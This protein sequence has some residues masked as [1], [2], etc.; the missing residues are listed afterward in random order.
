MTCLE[1]QHIGHDP[2]AGPALMWAVDQQW[3][4]HAAPSPASSDAMTWLDWSHEATFP[5]MDTLAAGRVELVAHVGSIHIADPALAA[6]LHRLS[7]LVRAL[8]KRFASVRWRLFGF[9]YRG[10]CVHQVLVSADGAPIVPPPPDTTVRLARLSN[11]I[12]S[13]A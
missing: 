11:R 5:D 6:S 4:V 10:E 13:A 9:G 7:R 12:K 2:K 3:T 1:Y 8:D